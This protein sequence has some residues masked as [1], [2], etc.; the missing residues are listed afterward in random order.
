MKQLSLVLLA[1]CSSAASKPPPVSPAPPPVIATGAQVLTQDTPETTRAGA[2]FIAPAGWSVERRG[3]AVIVGAPEAGSTIALVDVAAPDADAAVAAAWKTVRGEAPR[4]KLLQSIDAPDKDGWSKIKGYAYDVPPNARRAFGA[5]AM[6]ASGGWLVMLIDLDQGV[7]EK[8]GGQLGVLVSKLLPKGHTR[9]SFAGK[10]AHDLDAERLASIAKFISDGEAAMRVPGVGY[11]IIQHGKIVFAGGIG[12]RD[13]GKPDKI[14]ASTEFMI[15]SN[16]KQLTTLMLAKLVDDGKLSWDTL[17]TTI[18]PTFKLGTDDVTKQVQI[19]HLICACTGLPRQDLELIL[20][21]N[22]LTPEKVMALLAT[23]QPTSKFGEMF[24]YSNILAAA[25]G[26]VGGHLVYPKLELGAAY[27][28][29]MQTLVFDPLKM[30]ATTFDYARAQRGNHAVPHG[31]D[32]DGKIAYGPMIM[33]YGVAPMRPAGAAWSTVNDMLEYVAMELAKGKLPDGKPYI[34]EE[35]LRA[36]ETPQVPVGKDA[37]YGMGLMVDTTYGVTVVH[38][39]GDVFGFHSDVIWLPDFDVGAV[40][41]TNGDGGSAIRNGFRRKLLEVL[42]D[43]NPEAD[44]EIAADGKALAASLE[45]DRKQLTIPADP[46]AAGKLAAK[47]DNAA[48]GTIT[49]THK[50]GKTYFDFGALKSEMATKANPDGS[51]S[52][53]TLVPGFVGFELVVT[54]DTLVVRDAQHEYVYAPVR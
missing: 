28:K 39:G 43:G 21:G 41:L 1:A 35:P 7:A 33:N 8:R 19:K 5:N 26:F 51:V 2:T 53:V 15:A 42:F 36:R 20:N 16:T 17:V 54:G 11:G 23:I 49:V 12:V 10:Q 50:S 44:A 31:L 22:S 52:F 3:D 34:G 46:A 32:V 25:G 48:L 18:L 47:Y 37:T 6:Y 9:E 45:V 38:H 30:K 29:A 40:I 14:D 24:Q 4:W 13:I 27:D